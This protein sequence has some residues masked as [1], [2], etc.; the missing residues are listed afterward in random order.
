MVAADLMCGRID[1]GVTAG[2]YAMTMTIS[3]AQLEQLRRSAKRL[4]RSQS[5]PLSDAQNQLAVRNGFRNWSLMAKHS[6]SAQRT[7]PHVVAATASAH[8]V[9]PRPVLEQPDPRQR[10]YLHGDQYEPDPSRY[11]CAHCDVFFG[12]DH[13]AEHGPHTGER[14]L[15]R[16]E[17]W[18]KRDQRSQMTWRR[19]DNAVNI[20]EA[21]ALAARVQYQALRPKF[22]EWLKAQRNRAQARERLDEIAFMAWDFVTSRGLPTTPKSLRQL[23][24]HYRRRRGAQRPQLDALEAA[25]DEFLG[26]GSKA[27]PCTAP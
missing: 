7:A 13:F 2:T 11:Y 14:L 17:T 1:V 3:V 16:L 19:P 20:L 23:Q 9:Q 18:Q 25:W 15:E 21:G 22:S 4:S 27:V 8:L 6:A 10:Y 24:D 12:E 26:L 5:I